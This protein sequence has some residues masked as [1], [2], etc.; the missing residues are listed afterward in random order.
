[1]AYPRAILST[2]LAI[3][4]RATTL[5]VYLYMMHYERPVTHR[6]AIA[7]C[8]PIHSIDNLLIRVCL[9]ARVFITSQESILRFM[10]LTQSFTDFTLVTR[11]A[12]F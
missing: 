4:S 1:M 9:G 7:P 2:L 10:A 3:G 6:V 11:D 12:C 5:P 8:I